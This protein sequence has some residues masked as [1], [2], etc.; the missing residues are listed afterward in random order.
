[1]NVQILGTGVSLAPRVVLN[2]ELEDRLGIPRGFILKRT[3]IESR[4]VVN[5][6][7]TTSQLALPAALQALDNAGVGAD[8]VDLIIGACAVPDQ[9]IPAT[10]CF[11]QAALKTSGSMCFDVNASCFSF[12]VALNIAAQMIDSGQSKRALIFSADCASIGMDEKAPQSAVL[13]GD[14]GAAV[15]LGPSTGKSRIVGLKMKTFSEGRFLAQMRFGGTG[16][17]PTRADW[18]D[19]FARFEM[20]GK[21]IFKMA[22]QHGDGFLDDF[23][24]KAGLAQA[25]WKLAIPHQTS[26]HGVTIY[27]RKLGFRD[28]QVFSNLKDHGNCVSASIPMGLH[29]AITAGLIQRGDPVLL[30][31]TA[32]GLSLGVLGLVY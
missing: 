17:P 7:T 16:Q 8:D 6:G 18:D 28:D 31:G 19:K 27:S 11:V 23:F 4:R 9:A 14:G 26:L 30:L 20:D 24:A 10:A 13:F 2:D 25:D 1:M 15:V 12:P 32:A 29:Q 21:A 22:A 3:G 5:E